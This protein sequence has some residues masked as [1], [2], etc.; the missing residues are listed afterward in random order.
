MKKL[1]LVLVT[2]VIA[3]LVLTNIGCS[4]VPQEVNVNIIQEEPTSEEI[5]ETTQEQE[6]EPTKEPEVEPPPKPN[7]PD[8]SH[9]GAIYFRRPEPTY[10][11]EGCRP[12]YLEEFDRVI[13]SLDPDKNN[14]RKKPSPESKLLGQASPGTLMTIS[15]T[16]KCY[17]KDAYIYWYANIS[18]E[19]DGYIGEGNSNEMW[20]THIGNYD[21][22]RD[23]LPSSLFPYFVQVVGV[24]NNEWFSAETKASLLEE[25]YLDVVRKYDEDAF[26]AIVSMLPV[27]TEDFQQSPATFEYITQ[28]IFF[29]EDLPEDSVFFRDMPGTLAE[30]SNGRFSGTK[31]LNYLGI[32]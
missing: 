9:L 1:S 6:S 22:A 30:M 21:Y 27:F 32:D 31:L 28:N 23:Y 2:T 25:L 20:L 29:H 11:P 16:P 8:L 13:V 17:K 10:Y 26:L 15:G 5:T 24:M 3:I 7:Y 12:S 19:P 4:P 14:I 18:G